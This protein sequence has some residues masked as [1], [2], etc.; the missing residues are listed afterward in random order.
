MANL[1][2]SYLMLPSLTSHTKTSEI[3][4]RLDNLTSCFNC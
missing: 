2:A 4:E 3:T 1:L